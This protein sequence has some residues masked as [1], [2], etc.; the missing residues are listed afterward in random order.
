MAELE[1]RTAV[2]TVGPRAYMGT[3]GNLQQAGEERHAWPRR[4]PEK[5]LARSK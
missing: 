5:V 2:E 4:W 1:P 3:A